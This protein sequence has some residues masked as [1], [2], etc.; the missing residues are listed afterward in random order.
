MRTVSE[1]PHKGRSTNKYVCVC[2]EAQGRVRRAVGQEIE[3]D[4]QM[5][6][7]ERKRQME[8][9]DREWDIAQKHRNV[10]KCT[11]QK[12]LVIQSFLTQFLF[13]ACTLSEFQDSKTFAERFLEKKKKC[14]FHAHEE[15]GS[16]NH[17]FQ[18]GKS[19]NKNKQIQNPHRNPAT[20]A[21]ASDALHA[22]RTCGE[23]E[24][25]AGPKLYL[26]KAPREKHNYVKA[27]VLWCFYV[28]SNMTMKLNAPQTVTE[29]DTGAEAEIYLS[30]YLSDRHN[31]RLQG[32]LVFL[33]FCFCSLLEETIW[34]TSKLVP[35][36]TFWPFLLL[37]PILPSRWRM[38]K[39]RT[40]Y[41][42][43]DNASN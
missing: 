14:I 3:R 41:I 13:A 28:L 25:A 15:L 38:R 30:I 43:K 21:A 39:M 6:R 33:C 19:L 23:A 17:N 1:S 26:K 16:G 37:R 5:D 10:P 35:D 32:F 24:L 4:Q 18:N 7:E 36:L 20:S 12:P 42:C 40:C 2:V 8:S 27:L 9:K 29:C 22:A 11:Q 34:K 31:S